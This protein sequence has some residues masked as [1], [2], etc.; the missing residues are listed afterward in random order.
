[1]SGEK[2]QLMCKDGEIIE[3]DVQTASHSVLIKGMIDES[4]AEETVPL[5]Q[6]SKAIM[7]KIIIYCDRLNANQPPEIDKPLSSTDMF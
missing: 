6:V 5:P 4:G 1:M 2:V 7:D 3:V